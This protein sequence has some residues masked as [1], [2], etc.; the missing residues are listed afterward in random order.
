TIAGLK[1]S[2]GDLGNFRYVLAD[3]ADVKG[4]FVM[5][6][7]ELDVDAALLMGAHGCVPGLGNVDPAGYV[8]LWDAARRG[9]WEAA[10]REQER[11]CRLFDIIRPGLPRASVG[12][13]G[14]G[15][16]KT[17]LRAMGVIA[18]NAMARPQRSLDDGEAAQVV[19]VLR[20]VGLLAARV[21]ETAVHA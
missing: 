5:T 19:E 10:R 21:P 7:G 13:A 2:S 4:F 6:G 9:D 3:T 17:A 1:D 18:G 15:G 16:F 20:S 12:A 14:V 8:R 11:L